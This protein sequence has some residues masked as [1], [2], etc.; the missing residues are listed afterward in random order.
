MSQPST[1]GGPRPGA[2]RKPGSV[3]PGT[4]RSMINVKL[5]E[6]EKSLALAIGEG[7]ASEGVRRALAA[8]KSKQAATSKVKT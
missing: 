6:E 8:Q 2:G 3:K 4:K 7:N 5:T 1:H